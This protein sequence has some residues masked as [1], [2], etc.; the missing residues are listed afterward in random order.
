MSCGMFVP[1]I[2]VCVPVVLALL[3]GDRARVSLQK[4]IVRHGARAWGGGRV[5]R[6]PSRVQGAPMGVPALTEGT[7]Y[8]CSSRALLHLGFRTIRPALPCRS[9]APACVPQT[10]RP[11]ARGGSVL[12]RASVHV[13]FWTRLHLTGCSVSP[14]PV[15]HL[16]P[17]SRLPLHETL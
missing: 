4:V 9:H 1:T 6:Q 2:R 7:A 15:C 10:A 3:S 12:L 16:A 17:T 5:L 11:P 8:K 14:L 13:P